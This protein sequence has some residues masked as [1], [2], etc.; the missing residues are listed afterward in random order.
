M[1]NSSLPPAYHLPPAFSSSISATLPRKCQFVELCTERRK[2]RDFT[3]V[4]AEYEISTSVS[5]VS[6]WASA[7]RFHRRALK[8]RSSEIKSPR[9]VSCANFLILRIMAAGGSKADSFAAHKH[10]FTARHTHTTSRCG[11]P[12]R[13]VIRIVAPFLLAAALA[14]PIY[15]AE[16][17]A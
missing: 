4:L 14:T 7:C 9:S 17:S 8:A 2:A 3:D 16:A 10:R 12:Q 15:H 13:L 1:Q 5:E 6:P 11:L